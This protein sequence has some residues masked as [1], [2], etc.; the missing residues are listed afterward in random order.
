MLLQHETDGKRLET[1]NPLLIDF[2]KQSGW[3]EVV[4]PQEQV[5]KPKRGRPRKEAAEA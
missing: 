4:E 3:A 2:L 5:E 1:E